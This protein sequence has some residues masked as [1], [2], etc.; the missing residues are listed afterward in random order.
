M[1]IRLQPHGTVTGRIIDEDGRPRGGLSV[2]SAGGSMPGRLAEHGILPGVNL[3]GGIRVGRDGRFRIEGLVPGLKYGAG[4]S[5]SV[6]NYLGELF[7]DLTV[8]PGEIKD[9]GDIKIVPPE[10][11]M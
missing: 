8:A 4:A 10:R 7:H 5:E 11:D 2:T 3:G 6:L 9:L 1:T